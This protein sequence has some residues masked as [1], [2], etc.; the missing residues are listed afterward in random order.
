M[1]I[2]A[3]DNVTPKI[4]APIA[5]GRR[6]QNSG[7]KL[8][9]GLH[10]RFREFAVLRSSQA[11]ASKQAPEALTGQVVHLMSKKPPTPFEVDGVQCAVK[12]GLVNVGLNA[13][14]P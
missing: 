12:D 3:P 6:P 7:V 13:G 5:S 2:Q 11:D 8:L 14:W 10:F 9:N 4:I 1:C